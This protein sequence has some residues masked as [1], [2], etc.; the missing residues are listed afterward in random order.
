M[1][2]VNSKIP[3]P[4]EKGKWSML[5]LQRAFDEQNAQA[6]RII[7]SDPAKHGGESSLAVAWARTWLERHRR[8]GELFRP[9]AA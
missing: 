9:E 6:A 8:Q 4:H 5:A 7:L 3:K 2:S 1:G